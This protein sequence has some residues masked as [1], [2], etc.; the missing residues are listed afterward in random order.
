MQRWHVPQRQRLTFGHL[1]SDIIASTG[2]AERFL[3]TWR[4]VEIL[5]CVA[6]NS[7]IIRGSA[8]SIDSL[9]CL[10]V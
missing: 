7:S 8:S 9:P 2:G 10:Y 4:A 3:R 5:A 1:V 6:I